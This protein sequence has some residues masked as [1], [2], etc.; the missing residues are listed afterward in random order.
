MQEK[1]ISTII[2]SLIGVSFTGTI[3]GFKILW[4]KIECQKKAQRAIQDGVQSLLR[5][6]IIALY[7]KYSELGY[8]PIYEKENLQHLF[9]AYKALNGNGCID[10]LKK[11]MDELPTELPT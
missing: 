10:N 1:I 2:G 7:N 6:K 8:M 9:E 5:D 4:S 11:D 3:A